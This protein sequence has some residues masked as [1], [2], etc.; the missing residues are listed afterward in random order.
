[1][2][3]T[4][5]VTGSAYGTQNSRTAFLFCKSLIK[6]NHVLNSVFFYFDGVHNA[7]I[8]NTSPIDEFDLI[9]G[10]QTLNRKY[11]VQLY[12]C[13]TAALRRGIVGKNTISIFKKGNLSNFFKLSGLLDFG[14]SMHISDRIIQF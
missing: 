1:M 7:N 12:V 5:L 11:N 14:N 8:I 4:V 9:K 13:S 6:M 2:N 3:Y 10:W